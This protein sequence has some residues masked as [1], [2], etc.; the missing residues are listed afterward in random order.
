[1]T[2]RGIVTIKRYEGNQSDTLVLR[3][4]DALLEL[5]LSLGVNTHRTDLTVEV[6]EVDYGKIMLG[7]R[8]KDDGLVPSVTATYMWSP[9]NEQL[10][11][12]LL[13]VVAWW[14]HTHNGYCNDEV[15]VF[16]AKKSFKL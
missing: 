5:V 15:R 14:V 4:A 8:R 3:L 9:E 13:R 10:G 1:M 11:A 2:E 7:W 12:P 16:F 6:F